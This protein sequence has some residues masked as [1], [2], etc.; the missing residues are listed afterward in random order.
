MT[1]TLERIDLVVRHARDERP[2]F[3][4][5]VEEMLEIV[6]AV[7]GAEGLVLPVNR[8][9]ETAQE[10][11][12]PVAREERVPVRPPQDLDD[13]PAGAAEQPLQLLDDLPVAAHG[14]VKPLEVAVDDK[15]EVVEPLASCDRQAGKRFRLVHL[16]VAEQAPDAAARRVGEAAVGEV[17]HEARL[18]DRADRPD[19]HRAGRH[20][21]EVRHEPRM[22]IGAQAHAADLAAIALEVLLRQ[23]PLEK[24]ARI[25]PGSRVRLE[26]DEVAALAILRAAEEMVEADLE[27][28]GSRGVARNVAAKLSGREI[29]AHDHGERVPAYDRCYPLFERQIARI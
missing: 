10:R 2:H 6:R 24:G 4:I 29:G 7:L 22:G 27:N 3:R 23:P 17:A 13:M 1:A 21:P 5:L 20:L 16:A 15:G 18:I 26:K 14:A 9:G 19:P 8:R 25:D 12:R 28:F 11:M